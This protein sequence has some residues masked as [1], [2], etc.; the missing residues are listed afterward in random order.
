MTYITVQN[1][2]DASGIPTSLADDDTVEHAITMVEK[3]TERIMN[4]KFSP[5]L[6]IDVI[7]GNGLSYIFTHKNPVLRLEAIKSNDETI[8]TSSV[9]VYEYSGKLTL[10]TD[11]ETSEFLAKKQSVILKYRFGLMEKD[12]TL[13]TTTTADITAGDS[14]TI[15]VNDVT[16][17]AVNDWVEIYGMD[18]NKEVAQIT[19]ISD[20]DIVVDKLIYSHEADST[21]IKLEV[22]YYIK[23]FMELE[24]TIYLAMNA[25][26]ATYT[27]NAGYS[28]GDLNVQKGVPY[29]H[30]KESLSKA[31]K[32]REKFRSMIKPRFKIM[33]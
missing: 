6:R 14:V 17:F 1:V 16:D 11:S 13:Q 19:S 12:D 3:N 32:E 8:T 9:H 5:T 28:L 4:T 22:P 21:F 33:M 30:W 31:L 24:A 23:R 20:P 29:T 27:F 25:I 15:T 26:G 2:R 7:D 10:G 18:G